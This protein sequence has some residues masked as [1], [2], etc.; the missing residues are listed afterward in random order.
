MPGPEQP[1]LEVGSEERGELE[2]LVRRHSTEQQRAE[3][4]RIIVFLAD[5]LNNSEVARAAGVHLDTV[6]QW[7]RRW[8]A[9]RDVPL[10]DLDVAARLDD[11][12]RPGTPARITPEQVAR[13]VALA[14]EA[15]G[16]AGLPI[17][18]W[19]TT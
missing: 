5:G 19:S 14:C 3:R 9:V 6:R 2:R 15:P 16:E 8:D 18:Q 12:P 10:A 13:I 1:P 7:R 4:A 17:S 11:A